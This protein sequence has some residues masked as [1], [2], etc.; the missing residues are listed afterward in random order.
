MGKNRNE[1]RYY[2]T[3][4]TQNKNISNVRDALKMLFKWKCLSLKTYI[5]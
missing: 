5:R 2:K 3:F 4:L 1:K